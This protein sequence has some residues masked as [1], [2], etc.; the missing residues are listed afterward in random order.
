[1]Y[2]KEGPVYVPLFND[3]FRIR[4]FVHVKLKDQDKWSTTIC[5]LNKHWDGNVKL[6]L[7]YPLFPKTKLKCH[8]SIPKHDFLPLDNETGCRQIELYKSWDVISRYEAQNDDIAIRYPTFCFTPSQLVSPSNVW[9]KGIKNVYVVHY[10][11]VPGEP[12]DGGKLVAVEDSEICCFPMDNVKLGENLIASPRCFHKNTWHGLFLL[13]KALVKALNR[14]GRQAE[15]RDSETVSIGNI[16]TETF[17]YIY[18]LSNSHMKFLSCHF[19]D[20]SE[21]YQDIDDKMTRRKIRMSFQNGILRFATQSD[22]NFIRNMLGFAAV[23]GSS[24]VRPTLQDGDAGVTLKRGHFMTVIK[25][26]QTACE[27]KRRCYEQRID[28]VFS[29]FQV[30]VTANFQRFRYDRS[31][32]GQ[33]RT[34]PPTDHLDCVLRAKEYDADD[35]LFRPF[36]VPEDECTAESTPGT[37][38][39]T[40]S[41]DPTVYESPT[42]S[43]IPPSNLA[44]QDAT[45]LSTDS[46]DCP[47]SQGDEYEHDGTKFVVSMIFPKTTTKLYVLR[48][49]EEGTI[50]TMN[51][52][53]RYDKEGGIE[54]FEYLGT[55]HPSD[56]CLVGCSV[57]SGKRF[58]ACVS[59]HH[60]DMVFPQ[61]VSWVAS[62][63]NNYNK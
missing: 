54:G 39:S 50:F 59:S 5:Q 35:I 4:T 36:P 17:N 11:Q 38:S 43:G 16:P 29:P 40:D 24:K 7:F 30:R 26:S 34:T 61:D 58:K 63:V 12:G 46:S 32:S 57:V 56:G 20:G 28:V 18:I 48:H 19:V 45:P 6:S 42:T 53:V 52:P 15:R 2:E 51:D 49:Q 14:R 62:L 22:L 31:R 44:F 1:M 21:S 10:K 13:R 55:L 27:F 37:K 9:S 25:G 8:P 33:F 3:V 47:V 60:Q 41:S 23:Y